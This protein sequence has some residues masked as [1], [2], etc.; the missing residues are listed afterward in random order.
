MD[1]NFNFFLKSLRKK[2]GVS[3]REVE[4]HT[5][6]SNAYISQLENGEINKIPEPERLKKLA[7]YY[8]VTMEEI[9]FHAGYIDKSKVGDTL[10]ERINKAFDALLMHEMF[11]YANRLDKEKYDIELKRFI[12][13]MYEKL[14]GEKVLS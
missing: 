13:D 2:K 7:D 1:R 9:L 3:L 12:I 8:N 11:E 4:K 10:E 14:S 6:I 5:G